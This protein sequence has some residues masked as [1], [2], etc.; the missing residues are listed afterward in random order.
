[1]KTTREI[2]SEPERNFELNLPDWSDEL[3]KASSVDDTI[4]ISSES[5]GEGE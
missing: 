4:Y 3:P 2:D 1:M 5:E